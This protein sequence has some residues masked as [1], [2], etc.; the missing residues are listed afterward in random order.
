M[1][2]MILPL[3]IVV[4]AIIVSLLG[5]NSL[6]NYVTFVVPL[7]S[8]TAAEEYGSH[9]DNFWIDHNDA[10]YSFTIH[11]ITYNESDESVTIIFGDKDYI[12]SRS[13]HMRHQKDLKN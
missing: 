5:G 7:N 10:T 13:E 12:I 8:W 9:I 2:N 3:P 4:V 6:Y 11:K 1:N